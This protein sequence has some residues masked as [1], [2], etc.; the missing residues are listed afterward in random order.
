MSPTILDSAHFRVSRHP[1]FCALPC[2]LQ[3]LVSEQF[4]GSNRKLTLHEMNNQRS[5]IN[6]HFQH[7][8]SHCAKVSSFQSCIRHTG[9]SLEAKCKSE[10]EQGRSGCLLHVSPDECCPCSAGA[11]PEYDNRLLF[12]HRTQHV[13]RSTLTR[14]LRISSHFIDRQLR[15]DWR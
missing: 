15:K 7:T 12:Q 6:D 4:R 3:I 14:R 9:T 5:F 1:S 8:L 13:S 10:A 2:P 11:S